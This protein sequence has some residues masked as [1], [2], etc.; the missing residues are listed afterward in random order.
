MFKIGCQVVGDIAKDI[1]KHNIRLQKG[2]TLGTRDAG[3]GLKMALREQVRSAGLG[4]KVEKTWQDKEFPAGQKHSMSPAHLVFSKAPKLIEAYDKGVTIR[5]KNKIF[6]AIPTEDAPE[7]RMRGRTRVQV[8]PKT[9]PEERYGKLRFVAGKGG[10]AYLVASDLRRLY[11]QKDNAFRGFKKASAAWMKKGNRVEDVVM[12]IL[13]PQARMKKKLDV[14]REY[15]K[16]SQRH[17]DLIE[18]RL[19]HGD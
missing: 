11:R 18:K 3:R 12:F 1:Y 7:L 19:G 2:M 15:K 5:A 14:Q 17:V 13:I 6:L 4:P 10:Y 16:W 9:W 8:S